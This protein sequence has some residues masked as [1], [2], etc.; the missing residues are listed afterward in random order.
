MMFLFYICLISGCVAPLNNNLSPQDEVMREERLV[1]LL[2]V[3]AHQL[4]AGSSSAAL[5]SFELA[6]ELSPTDPR[7]M[8]ALGCVAW[9][10]Q[11]HVLAKYYFQEA[12]RINPNYDRAYAHLALI[13]EANGDILAAKELLQIAIRLNPLNYR[14]RNNYAAVLIDELPNHGNENKEVVVHELLKALQS[15][16]TENE[17]VMMYNLSNVK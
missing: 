10:R 3:G 12:I 1:S 7:V 17:R 4:R 9:N 16:V 11:E 14:A 15:G 5:A 6:R 13:A 2:T 8:D